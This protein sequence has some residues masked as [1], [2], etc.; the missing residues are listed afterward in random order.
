MALRRVK[1][2]NGFLGILTLSTIILEYLAWV[3]QN[4]VKEDLLQ[5]I[6]L[7][8]KL[9]VVYKRSQVFNVDVL[10]LIGL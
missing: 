10:N 3:K 4:S 8:I 1:I 9:R 2:E 6:K 5:K 7:R